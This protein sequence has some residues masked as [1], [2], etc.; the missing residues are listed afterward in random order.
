MNGTDASRSLSPWGESI[1][2][3][4]DDPPAAVT[5]FHVERYRYILQQL[6]ATNENVHRFLGIYQTLATALAGAAITLFVGYREWEISASIARVG[7]VGLLVLLTLVALFTSLLIV[8]SVLT[9]LD[10]R[11]E[12]C[13][14]TDKAVGPQFRQPPAARNFFRWY[15]T[16]VL[17]FIITSLLALWLL[18]T[19]LLLPAM[20]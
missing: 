9:W 18:A 20:T 15:E 17:G 2:A 12:E 4:S 14:L 6:H 3:R 19:T 16:Y 5:E 1:M 8:I 7:V 10:Y 13:A 11:R